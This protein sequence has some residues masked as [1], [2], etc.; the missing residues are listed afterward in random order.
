MGCVFRF[1]VAA[2]GVVV[3]VLGFG[4]SSRGA[5][6]VGVMVL[7]LVVVGAGFAVGV[8]RFVVARWFSSVVSR[9]LPSEGDEWRLCAN[10]VEE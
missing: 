6:R 10:F 7:G 4:F 8:L 2:L 9:E 5:C 3:V 1:V